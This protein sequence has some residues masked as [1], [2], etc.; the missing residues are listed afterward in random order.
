MHLLDDFLTI[1]P[2][3]YDADR[4]MALLTMIFNKLSVPLSVHKTCGPVQVLEYLGIILDTVKMEARLPS[5]KMERISV[6]LSD[7]LGKSKCRQK[8]LLSLIGHLNFA[9]KVIPA[10]R[11]F[12]SRLIKAA[13]TVK[14]LHHRV[15]LTSSAK[16]DIKMWQYLLSHWNGISLFLENDVTKSHDLTLYT[17]ASA[18][19]GFGAFF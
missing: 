2:P 6:M 19:H 13:Y 4:T 15:H 10:G 7:F 9:C 5:D 3:T 8:S 14:K 18:R 17:D 12:M 1:D 16:A 11:S